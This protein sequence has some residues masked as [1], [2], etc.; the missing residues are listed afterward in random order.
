MPRPLSFRHLALAAI[1]AMFVAGRAQAQAQ[2]PA[3]SLGTAIGVAYG[4]SQYDFSG[5]GTVRHGALRVTKPLASILL[6]EVGAGLM[7]Y[8]TQGGDRATMIFPEA[9]LQ[10]QAPLGRVAPYLGVG[11]G[12]V[13]GFISDAS[14][15][16]ATIS[17]AG[18]VRVGLTPALA[19]AAELRVRGTGAEFTGSTAEW[20][21]GAAWRP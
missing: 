10:L 9:Q 12:I 14:D 1:A 20:T 21:L 16:D 3:T 2:A 8:K 7:R 4:V 13:A 6:F 19:L 11:G 18:G 5:T 15:V 17:G